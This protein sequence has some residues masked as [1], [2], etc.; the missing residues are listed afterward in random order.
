MIGNAPGQRSPT[1]IPVGILVLLPLILMPVA[2]VF[3]FALKGARG[4]SGRRS[5]PRTRSSPSA[6][7]C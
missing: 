4:S 3:V 6:S 2:A 7:A 1:A 5:P